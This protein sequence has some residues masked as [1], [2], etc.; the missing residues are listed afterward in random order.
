MRAILAGAPY[1]A[2]LLQAAVRRIRAEQAVGYPRAAIIKASLNRLIRQNRLSAK[3][4]SVSLDKNNTDPAYCLGRLF[5]TLE[6]IQGVAQPGINATIRERYYAAASS[7]PVTVFP[8]LLKLK[9]HHLAK[10]DRPG[11]V[12][13]FEKLLTEIFG[14]IDA[15]PPRLTL[16]EQGAFAI[17]YYHQQQAF[18]APKG[19]AGAAVASDADNQGEE[20]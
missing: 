10:I 7:A 18:F 9:N 16:A 3:E 4:L 8:I 17:G 15:V 13:M 2:M 6:R 14:C 20:E 5:A 19:E 11:L 1:P 12:V